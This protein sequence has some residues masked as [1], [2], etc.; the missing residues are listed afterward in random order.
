[1]CLSVRVHHVHVDIGNR[2]LFREYR[3]L[4]IVGRAPQSLLLRGYSQ[5]N[6][7]SLWLHRL[8]LKCFGDLQQTSYPAGIIHGSVIDTVASCVGLA[9]TQVVPVTGIDDGLVRT[10][11]AGD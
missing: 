11:A 1:F 8:G 4:G 9:Y 6:D 5:K 10:A 3:V 7:R 2:L